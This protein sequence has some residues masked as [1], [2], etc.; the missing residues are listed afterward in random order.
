MGEGWHNNHHFYPGSASQ[1]FFWWEWD[2]SYYLLRLLALFRVVWDLRTPP[3][4][5]KYAYLEGEAVPPHAALA[6]AAGRQ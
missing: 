5:V 3:P 1:G 4:S 6:S 2:P